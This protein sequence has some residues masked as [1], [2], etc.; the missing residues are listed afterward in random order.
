MEVTLL[1]F[2]AQQFRHLPVS[3]FRSAM[4]ILVQPN[5]HKVSQEK[6]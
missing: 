6:T 5:K 2:I 4:C 3:K 1:S